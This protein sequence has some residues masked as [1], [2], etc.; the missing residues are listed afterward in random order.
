MAGHGISLN[1][2]QARATGYL[3]QLALGSIS[4]ACHRFEDCSLSAPMARNWRFERWMN[5]GPFRNVHQNE[6]KEPLINNT[7]PPVFH[8]HG[9]PDLM[10]AN[11]DGFTPYLW[12]RNPRLVRLQAQFTCQA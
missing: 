5:S 4:C 6:V 9:D 10:S 1:F 12:G 7:I 11:V 3:S 2:D 8:G